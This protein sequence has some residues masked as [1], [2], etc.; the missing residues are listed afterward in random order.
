MKKPKR[1][2]TKVHKCPAQPERGIYGE[3]YGSDKRIK[4]RTIGKEEDHG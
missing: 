1:H 2:R 3:I 4:E